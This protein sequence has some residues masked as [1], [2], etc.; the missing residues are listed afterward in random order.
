M[1]WTTG[2]KLESLNCELDFAAWH[3]PGRMLNDEQDEPLMVIG[4][5]KS[6]GK[7]SISESTV[8]G[9]K[10]VTNRFPGAIMI[11]SSARAGTIP[12]QPQHPSARIAPT[13]FAKTPGGVWDISMLLAGSA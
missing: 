1:T 3:R 5:A 13:V 9:L 12:R 6:F 7:N 11:V 10:R 2:L 8:A 4:E